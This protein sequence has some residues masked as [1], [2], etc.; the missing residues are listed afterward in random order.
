M[1]K[2]AYYSRAEAA[3]VLGVCEDIVSKYVKMGLLVNLK[4]YNKGPMS[5]SAK[6]IEKF[7][8]MGSEVVD[9][10][11]AI[12]Q[13]K[14]EAAQMREELE[15]EKEKLQTEMNHVSLR[16]FLYMNAPMINQ[17]MKEV[18]SFMEEHVGL[19]DREWG[20]LKILCNGGKLEDGSKLYGLTRERV[21]QIANKALRRLKIH[22]KSV[23]Y[24]EEEVMR[25]REEVARLTAE[26][27]L[28]DRQLE[29]NYAQRVEDKK[30]AVVMIPERLSRPIHLADFLSVRA[31]NCMCIFDIEHL[32]QLAWM[33]KSNLLR[34]RNFGKKSMIELCDFLEEYG[35]DFGNEGVD[36]MLLLTA[37]PGEEYVP[38][39]RAQL[40][41]DM[42]NTWESIGRHDLITKYKAGEL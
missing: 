39:P 26:N 29:I 2:K 23:G 16:T 6:S 14:A 17:T 8:S 4:K 1:G 9:M 42:L 34:L 35:L 28:K 40:E 41:E 13:A 18:L 3:E 19:S 32:Y 21:N 20:I 5:I 37:S 15:R 25:L 22:I 33:S 38:V 24:R 36:C 10:H 30:D 11:K 7:L 27:K 12:K 31:I